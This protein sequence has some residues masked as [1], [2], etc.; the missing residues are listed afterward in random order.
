M[1]KRNCFATV[2]SA[3][4]GGAASVRHFH[5]FGMG[6]KGGTC[7]FPL[8][9]ARIRTASGEKRSDLRLHM[10]HRYFTFLRPLFGFSSHFCNTFFGTHCPP[11]RRF[12][13]IIAQY[14]DFVNPENNIQNG[15]F[16]SVSHFFSK[17]RKLTVFS[18]NPHTPIIPQS[19]RLRRS[20][21]RS[22]VPRNRLSCH[23]PA[24]R[25]VRPAHSNSSETKKIICPAHAAHD[26]HMIRDLIQSFPA[27][28]DLPPRGRGTARRRWKE[29]VPLT[30]LRKTGRIIVCGRWARAPLGLGD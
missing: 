23:V 15:F 24:V 9:I 7:C 18:R 17:I 30:R 25:P 20:A 8:E 1:W 14:F 3:C 13:P 12:F 16:T 6:E 2:T 22:F 26:G 11:P 21:D 4:S 28:Q 27:P 29:F 19:V 5:P 10:M